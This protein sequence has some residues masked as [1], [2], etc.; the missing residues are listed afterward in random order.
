MRCFGRPKFF[1]APWEFPG[2]LETAVRNLKGE[3]L[4]SGATIKD[5][6]ERYVERLP[7]PS[8]FEYSSNTTAFFASDQNQR[9]L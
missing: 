8:M 2:K 9:M 3:L 4:R 1:V 7:P 6:G 5:Q